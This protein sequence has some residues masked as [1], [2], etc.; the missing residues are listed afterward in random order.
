MEHTSVCVFCLQ[1]KGT[2]KPYCKDNPG[3]GCTYGFYHEFDGE[4]FRPKVVKKAV[5]AIDKQV[6]TFCGI[7]VKNPQSASNGCSHQYPE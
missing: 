2:A 6:C 7:H 5:K 4:E 3:E 1:Y